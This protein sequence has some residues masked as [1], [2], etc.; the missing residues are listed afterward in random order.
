MYYPRL[1][2]KYII[3]ECMEMTLVVREMKAKGTVDSAE[4]RVYQA[5]TTACTRNNCKG[6]YCFS[7]TNTILESVTRT[8]GTYEFE[9][10]LVCIFMSGRAIL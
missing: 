9:F 4:T 6:L 7:T 10:T 8:T 2:Q 1:E 3:A 5:K